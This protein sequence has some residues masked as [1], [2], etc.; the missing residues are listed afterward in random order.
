MT[1]QQNTLSY[2]EQRA[3]QKALAAAIDAEDDREIAR[4]VAKYPEGATLSGEDLYLLGRVAERTNET[5][6][7]EMLFSMSITSPDVPAW[8]K[9]AA[10]SSM[11]A[12]LERTARG[13]EAAPYYELS[14][15]AK[16]NATGWLKEYS[17]VLFYSH[18]HAGARD[19]LAAAKVYG[20]HLADIQPYE[21][22]PCRRHE[23]I[24]I[25]Y[26]SADLHR[27]IVAFFAYAMLRAYDHGAFEVYC[28]MNGVEDSV[29]ETFRG[30]VD[31]WR[32]VRGMT[33]ADIAAQIHDDEIDILFDLGGHTAGNLLPVFA[34]RPAPIQMTG[35]GYFDT[36]GVPQ[37][38]YFL[39]DCTTLPEGEP[40]PFTEQIVRMEHSH[41]C[42]MWHGAPLEPQPLPAGEQGFITFGSL[43]DFRKVTDDVLRAW[44]RI[45]DA[46]PG[47][48]LLLKAGIFD[49]DYGA[50]FAYERMHR[51]GIDWKRVD[52][53]GRT[54]DYLRA[55][56]RIDIALDTFPYPG[57]GTTCDALYMGVPVVTLAGPSHHERF[58]KSLLVNA[59][60][61]EL[62]AETVDDYVAIAAQLANDLP[63]LR[64]LHET[65]RRELRQSPVTDMAGYIVELEQHYQRMYWTW[66]WQG[67]SP[68]QR[69]KTLEKT[70][71]EL[72]KAYEAKDYD[73]IIIHGTRLLCHPAYVKQNAGAVGR[74]YMNL[75]QEDYVRMAWYFSHADHTALVRQIEYVWLT[76]LA[77]NRLR[78]HIPARELYASAMDACKRAAE[79]KDEASRS[80]WD[81]PL[82]LTELSLEAAFNALI[83]GD[84]E[85]AATFYRKASESTTKFRSRCENYGSYLMA[86]H[87]MDLTPEDML[88]AHKGF[89]KIFK[90]VQRYDHAHHAHHD[91]IRVGYI[92]GDFRRHVMFYFYYQLFAGHDAEHFELYAYSLG[93]THDGF[94]DLVKQAVDVFRDV[95]DTDLEK[96]AKTIY[97]DEIDILVDL[98]GHTSGSGLSVLGWKPAPVQIS[99][100][101]YMDTTGLP[102]VD[103]LITDRAC[104]PEDAPHYLTEQ[105]LYVTSMFCYT[106][107]SDVPACQGAPCKERGYVTFGVFNRYQK[108][109]DEMLT[110]WQQIQAAVPGSRLLCKAEAYHDDALTDRAYER[111]AAMG[112]DMERVI[113]EPSSDDYMERYL[114]VDIALDTYPYVGGGTTCDALYMGVPVVSRYGAGHGSRFGLSVLTAAGLGELAVPDG[115]AYVARAIALAT[116]T[117]LLDALHRNLRTMLFASPLMDTQCYVREM[118]ENYTAIWQAYETQNGGRP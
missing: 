99:G 2:R 34:Y 27:H 76:A 111:F 20:E 90:D 49:D 68:T 101:G 114:S 73:R 67:K 44:A 23:K 46:V 38:D 25:G 18:D 106:G 59:G 42:Y 109:T 103:Y 55:Y 84:V 21:Y 83:L 39:A 3:L 11:A 94:R 116:D 80:F 77:E 15:A 112:F 57:G 53:E 28:Y 65:L 86:L 40:A 82:F 7:A 35:I 6:K 10:A 24:R 43:N 71:R 110:L 12:L 95:A 16:D 89:A 85:R 56:E 70:E 62:C 108:I 88:A 26:V 98:G 72:I 105:P 36:T 54:D 117:E 45:L 87:H 64:H 9:G 61:P 29:S 93:H 118:E 60:H 79:Q 51:A 69:E 32:N 96:I 104:D 66:L 113:F 30:W 91:R 75:P 92:S 22:T 33:Y 41:L 50:S 81:N 1:K 63:R 102:D 19:A 13:K 17:N 5:E 107:R 14:L 48:R 74:A 100:L 37:M 78:H 58:G 52:T 4:L 115:A 97:D 31:G 47:S 8:C